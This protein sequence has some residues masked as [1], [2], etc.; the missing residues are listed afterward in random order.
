[1]NPQ[2]Q[3]ADSGPDADASGHQQK[4]EAAAPWRAQFEKSPTVFL[5]AALGGGLLIG[6]ASNDRKPRPAAEPVRDPK[7]AP[8]HQRLRWDWNDSVGV[9]KSVLIGIAITQAK[10]M[11]CDQMPDQEPKPGDTQE[12]PDSS[13]DSETGAPDSAMH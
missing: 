13:S 6:I 7:A 11:L 5:A 9:V 10:K 4:A 2:T 12:H 3:N 8:N 1:M